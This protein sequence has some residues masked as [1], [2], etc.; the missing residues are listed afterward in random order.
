[1]PCLDPG[2]SSATR[3]TVSENHILYDSPLN[4]I[5]LF[6]YKGYSFPFSMLILTP[7]P[8]TDST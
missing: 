2:D 7:S 3:R 5:T 4:S 6:I 1:M 8:I